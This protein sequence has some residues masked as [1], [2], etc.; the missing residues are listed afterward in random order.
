MDLK[1][2]GH[3]SHGAAFNFSK[4]STVAYIR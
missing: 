4:P 1:S 2:G 3:L